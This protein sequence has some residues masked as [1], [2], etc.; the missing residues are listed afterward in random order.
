MSISNVGPAPVLEYGW[1]LSGDGNAFAVKAAEQSP[2][3]IIWKL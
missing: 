2:V 3:C 1:L